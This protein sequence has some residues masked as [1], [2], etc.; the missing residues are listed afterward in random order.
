MYYFLE[1]FHFHLVYNIIKVDI[2][3]SNKLLY[4]RTVPWNQ[5]MWTFLFFYSLLCFI[6]NNIK[7]I[8]FFSQNYFLDLAKIRY[9]CFHLVYIALVNFFYFVDYF[10]P[11]YYTMFFGSEESQHEI[12]YFLFAH[13]TFFRYIFIDEFTIDSFIKSTLFAKPIIYVY[14]VFGFFCLMVFAF[15]EV[16]F[17]LHWQFLYLV[18]WILDIHWLNLFILWIRYLVVA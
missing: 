5:L 15:V 7:I 14:I 1:G 6:F 10:P 11:L 9:N 18:H 8:V 17:T 13:R 2:N 16:E 3:I 4:F 12:L